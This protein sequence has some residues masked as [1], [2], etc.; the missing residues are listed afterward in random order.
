YDALALR[1]RL[2]RER[3]CHAGKRLNGCVRKRGDKVLIV[4]KVLREITTGMEMMLA[5]GIGRHLAV[6]AFDFFA[7]GVDIDHDTF[8]R[9]D[10][11]VTL[12]C[13]PGLSDRTERKLA[14]WALLM[15]RRSN[16]TPGRV[17]AV[18]PVRRVIVWDEQVSAGDGPF[19]GG[20]PP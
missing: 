10:G 2:Q 16:A 12:L 1:Q 14:V 8:L 17:G 13:G 4:A 3:I 6:F 15:K 20:R 11:H 7:Q 18:K 5:V 19:A 9:I